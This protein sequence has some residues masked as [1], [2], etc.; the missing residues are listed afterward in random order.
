MFGVAL[1]LSKMQATN[2]VSDDKST[3]SKKSDLIRVS[4]T[5]VRT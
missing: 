5:E 1:N 2:M 3:R 4:R